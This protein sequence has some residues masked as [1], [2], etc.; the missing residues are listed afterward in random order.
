M[1]S[2]QI[3]KLLDT[4]VPKLVVRNYVPT[5]YQV[6]KAW[7]QAHNQA[8]LERDFLSDTGVVIEYQGE[9]VMMGWLYLS[10]SK[11]AQ[12]GWVV[13]RP[14]LSHKIRFSAIALLLDT[15][16]QMATR[17]G[18]RMVQMMSDQSGLTRIA[19]ICGFKTI[20]EH[21]FLCKYIQEV[22]EHDEI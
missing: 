11:I 15:A 17:S 9:A 7:W 20:R 6:A 1:N 2:M 16:E 5:D 13:S 3:N 21:T 19:E 18:Y 14:Q 10:N 4:Y 8:Y 12:F 22:G